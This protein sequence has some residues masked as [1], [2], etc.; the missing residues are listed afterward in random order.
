MFFGLLVV[1]YILSYVDRSA[2]G[3][4]APATWG[5]DATGMAA[6]SW[7]W[8][9]DG[10]FTASTGDWQE[11]PMLIYAPLFFLDTHYWHDHFRLEPGD[12]RHPEVFPGFK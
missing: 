8:A 6:R 5:A 4:Y 7:Q 12:P 3:K 2:R 1:L 11:K 10:F 9:P